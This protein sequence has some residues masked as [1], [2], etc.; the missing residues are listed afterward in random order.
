MCS[1]S[2]GADAAAAQSQAQFAY[3]Q[4][5][6]AEAAAK[7]ARRQAAIKTGTKQVN[8]MYAGYDQSYYDGIANDYVQNYANPQIQVQQ[9]HDMQ[10][11][12]FAQARSGLSV[13]SAAAKQFG[14][15]GRVYG[16]TATDAA[17]RG[18][19]MAQDRNTQVE[20]S[21]RAAL[22]ALQ[23]A[24]D[25]LST[26][27]NAQQAITGYSVSPAALAITDLLNSAAQQA[28]RS[29]A[30]NILSGNSGGGG[31]VYSPFYGS[32]RGGSAG[33]KGTT[34]TINA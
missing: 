12:K 17:A 34:R 19:Q 21:R 1:D 10:Q 22:Q 27:P 18:Q 5:Q 26:V 29:Y 14:D 13:S 33:G 4:Q 25:P 3:Q 6:V 7:E 15:I 9:T 28:S 16:Q 11:A 8:D 24:N 2:G 32:G 31:N 30:N 20:G 23:V